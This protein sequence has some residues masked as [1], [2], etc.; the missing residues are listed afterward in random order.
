MVITVTSEDPDSASSA[1]MTDFG[2]FCRLQDITRRDHETGRKPGRNIVAH[3]V[4]SGCCSSEV[5]VFDIF[6][7]NHGIH[8]INRLIE[9]YP[10]SASQHHVK[11]RGNNSIR[12]I[13]RHSLHRSLRNSQVC[14]IFGI[15]PYDHGDCG[16]CALCIS[17]GQR[18]IHLHALLFQRT[19][20]HHLPAHHAFH[21]HSSQWMN[22]VR[23]SQNEHRGKSCD[24]KN[25]DNQRGSRPSLRLFVCR[26]PFAEP[27]LQPC[28]QVTD[29]A[30]RMGYIPWISKQ[31]IEGTARKCSQYMVT[32]HL[33][34]LISAWWRCRRPCGTL[35]RNLPPAFRPPSRLP[36]AMPAPP[37]PPERYRIPSRPR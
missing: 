7:S 33:F 36:P 30:D 26:K 13:F 9:K 18:V 14:E 23:G 1:V 29:A 6:I 4:Q 17:G 20:R 21:R 27:C 11:E 3:I 8:G 5:Y 2:S 28:D 37:G 19:P 31:R 16:S 35:L 32:Y 10:G 22:R 24:Q 34:S 15:P 25:S 12:G